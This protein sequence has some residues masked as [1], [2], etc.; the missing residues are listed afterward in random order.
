MV[1]KLE[2]PERRALDVEGPVHYREWDGPDE[3]TFVLVHGLGGS[4]L[5]WTSVAPQLSRHGRVLVPDL[6]IGRASCRERVYVLV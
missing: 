2:V 1:T 3:L 6:Q 4:H 5:S